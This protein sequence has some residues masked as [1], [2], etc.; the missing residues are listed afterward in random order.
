MTRRIS[1]LAGALMSLA[2]VACAQPPAPVARPKVSPP[3]LEVKEETTQ[4]KAG[5]ETYTFVKREHQLVGP[6]GVQ[7]A[8]TEWWELRDPAGK[9]VYRE[10]GAPPKLTDQGDFEETSEVSASSA[11]ADG[12][13]VILVEGMQLPSAPNSGSWVQV[14]GRKWGS[15]TQPLTSFGPAIS[16]EGEF[17]GL[18]ID[19]RRDAP[20]PPRPGVTVVTLHDVLKFRVWTGNFEIEYPVLINWITGRVEPAMRCYRT[21]MKGRIERCSYPI[22]VDPHRDGN[23]LTFVRMFHEPEELGTPKH[24]V[25]KPTSKIEFLEAEVPVTWQVDAKNI[26]IGASGPE[27]DDTWVKVRIDGQEGWIHTQEDFLA[28]GLPQ[29][30]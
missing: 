19:H 10:S 16:T 21:T 6:K 7:D 20:K 22:K 13:D 9:V 3:K 27:S 26:F 11:H 25:I 17:T 29:S 23:D 2:A 30:G 14:F 4:L 18:G 12:G 5:A 28:I 15:A 1:F 24:V 8:S